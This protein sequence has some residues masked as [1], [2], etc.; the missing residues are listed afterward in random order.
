MKQYK[1][2]EKCLE[3]SGKYD[4]MAVKRIGYAVIKFNRGSFDINL[5]S[6]DFNYEEVLYDVLSDKNDILVTIYS[7]LVTRAEISLEQQGFE[8]EGKDMIG[9][10]CGLRFP[11]GYYTGHGDNFDYGEVVDAKEINGKFIYKYVSDYGM[12][13]EISRGGIK[14]IKEDF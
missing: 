13:K 1:L 8:V 7:D 11:F 14:L 3:L 5:R 9:R 2:F 6:K 4:V 12:E 10:E